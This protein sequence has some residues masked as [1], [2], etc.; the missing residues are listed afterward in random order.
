LAPTTNTDLEHIMPLDSPAPSV[1]GGARDEPRIMVYA[2]ARPLLFDK[3]DPCCLQVEPSSLVLLS[4]P[5]RRFTF[6]GVLGPDCS[7]QE[8]FSACAL[9][10]CRKAVAGYNASLYV[11]GQTGSGKTF[12]MLGGDNNQP[13][14]GSQHYGL[15]FRI[16]DRVFSDLSELKVGGFLVKVSCLEIYCET[17]SDLMSEGPQGEGLQLREHLR[18]GVYVEG[19]TEVTVEDPASAHRLL[20]K[21][22]LSRHVGSTLLNSRSSRSHCVFTMS[23]ETTQ[24]QVGG[25]SQTTVSKLHLVDLAGSER[26][27]TLGESGSRVKEAGAINKSLS[28]LMNVIL[29]LSR[30][31]TASTLSTP[32]GKNKGRSGKT[33]LETREEDLNAHS[34]RVKNM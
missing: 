14:Q 22:L 7:Q 29:M 4:D 21:A 24:P 13:Q 25:L 19:L 16:I 32:L 1:D 9:D 5:P 28:C 11:Y 6:D 12:T 15:A 27:Q 2:R 30:N 20:R 34:K 26:Q 8:V 3:A 31:S 10:L 18:Q 23:I 17:V 33:T